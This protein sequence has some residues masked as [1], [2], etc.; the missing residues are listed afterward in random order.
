MLHSEMMERMTSAE[1][2]RWMA[3]DLVEPFGDRRGDIQAGIVAQTMANMWR[4]PKQKA[5]TLDL[6]LP[7]FSSDP[8]P[9][10]RQQTVEEQIAMWEAIMI[11]QNASIHDCE[12]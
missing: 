5:F 3:M 10:K 8:E 9:P 2:Y 6:F 7:K 4:D 11:A 12:N 1:F